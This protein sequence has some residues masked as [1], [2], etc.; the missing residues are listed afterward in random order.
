MP[1]VHRKAPT[2]LVFL[3]VV[4]GAAA[5]RSQGVTRSPSGSGPAALTPG[6]AAEGSAPGWTRLPQDTTRPPIERTVSLD[7]ALALL[8]ADPGGNID[9]SAALQQGVI[10]PRSALPGDTSTGE[11]PELDVNY[12]FKGENATFT[13]V[14]P[15]AAHL[16]WLRCENC[17]PALFPFGDPP[18][19]TMDL[20]YSG[21]SCGVCHA[22]VSFPATACWRCHAALPPPAEPATE[23]V[24]PGAGDLTLARKPASASR[25]EGFP[26]ARF[27]H[28]VHR[29]RYTCSTCHDQLFA[30]RAG[31]DTL[32][33]DS[34][35]EGKSCGRCHNGASTFALVECGRCHA[36]APKSG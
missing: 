36:P 21:Q 31:A 5:A 15:H 14:F 24:P 10:R 20:I 11:A 27:S 29:I 3:G 30:M 34:M 26:P 8:P 28:W 23:K 9:W 16:K 12:E 25:G 22:K 2:A 13:A 32:D 6:P 18:K 33:M 35:R 19:P 7:S 4:L 1:L 17:H